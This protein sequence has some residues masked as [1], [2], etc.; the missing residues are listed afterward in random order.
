MK[1]RMVTA[2]KQRT[3][4]GSSPVPTWPGSR[5]TPATARTVVCFPAG[6]SARLACLVRPG[7]ALAAA[8]MGERPAVGGPSDLYCGGGAGVSLM[9]W[10]I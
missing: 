7:L 1:L 2:P 4:S 6:E 9:A 10:V 5:H 3:M 8:G